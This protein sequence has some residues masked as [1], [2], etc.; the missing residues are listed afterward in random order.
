MGMI[1]DPYLGAAAGCRELSGLDRWR[2]ARRP[3]TRRPIQGLPIRFTYR[4]ARVLA[5]I[6]AHPGASNR[7]IADHSGITDEGQT[8]RLLG[9]LSK[10]GLIENHGVGPT[11]ASPRLAPH[12]PRQGVPRDSVAVDLLIR[13]YQ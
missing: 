3:T 2:R 10:D 13:T 9:R 5:T 12:R 11:R 4:T 1:V 8:S 7:H 6:A